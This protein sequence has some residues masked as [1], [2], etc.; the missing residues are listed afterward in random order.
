VS[1]PVDWDPT[2]SFDPGEQLQ[3][4]YIQSSN[5][6]EIKVPGYDWEP[7]SRHGNIVSNAYGGMRMSISS[8]GQYSSLFSWGD[9]DTYGLDA[10]G[11]ATPASGIPISG[12]ASYSGQILGETTE[13]HSNVPMAIRGPIELSFDFGLGRLSGSISPVLFRY[14]DPTA[15]AL[16]T[17][18]FSDTV[19]SAGSTSFSGKFG[20]DLAGLNSFSGLFTGPNAEELIGNFAFPYRSPIDGQPHQADGAFMAAK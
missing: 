5:S 8:T 6:Y 2:P 13:I 9:G 20:T 11:M 14:A 19:Y 15:N 12:S 10:I 16:G 4:R 1:Y 18:S 3:V 7:V 17:I